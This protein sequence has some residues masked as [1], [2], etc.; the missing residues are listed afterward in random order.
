MNSL[1][2]VGTET[3]RPRRTTAHTRVR[4][5]YRTCSVCATCRSCSCVVSAA[6]SG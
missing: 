5:D 3:S 4:E 6:F 2:G 1:V